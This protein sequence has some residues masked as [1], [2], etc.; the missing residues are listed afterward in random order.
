MFCPPLSPAISFQTVPSS[1]SANSVIHQA[2]EE[3]IVLAMAESF[4]TASLLYVRRPPAL[5]VSAEPTTLLH[6]RVFLQIRSR[7]GIRD[8]SVKINA[9]HKLSS[10]TFLPSRAT[11]LLP[12]PPPLR[13]FFAPVT[14]VRAPV[15]AAIVERQTQN[16]T[17]QYPL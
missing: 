6:L 14:M 4:G 9:S 13:P 17:L 16:Q 15:T 5:L 11:D 8:V 7:Q 2:F 10:V 1:P 3:N 12:A